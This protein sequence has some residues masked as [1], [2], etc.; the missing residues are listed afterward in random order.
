MKSRQSWTI[1]SVSLGLSEVQHA[2]P[3][4]AEHFFVASEALF[5]V[6]YVSPL[7]LP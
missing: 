4:V 5:L 6:R 3:E 2:G 7:T 1:P